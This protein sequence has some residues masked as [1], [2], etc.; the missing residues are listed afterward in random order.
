MNM[1]K[2]T[3]KQQAL[4]FDFHQALIGYDIY[5]NGQKADK[6]EVF[7]EHIFKADAYNNLKKITERNNDK[8]IL[9][10]KNSVSNQIKAT[11]MKH[12]KQMT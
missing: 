10:K 7:Y 12:Q 6:C 4:W 11:W 2:L 5:S 3:E 9:V 8:Y 1:C